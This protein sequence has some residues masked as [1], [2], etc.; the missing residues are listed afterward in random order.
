MLPNRATHHKWPICFLVCRGDSKFKLALAIPY[1]KLSLVAICFFPFDK[2]E[3]GHVG[4]HQ[5]HI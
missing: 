2:I 4:S 3:I 1:D 5:G